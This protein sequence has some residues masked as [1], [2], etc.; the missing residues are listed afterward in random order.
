MSA[1]LRF[2][3]ACLRDSNA[4][5]LLQAN[6]DIFLD[7]QEASAHLYILQHVRAYRQL[8]SPDAV[9]AETGVN[10]PA[11][12]RL[13]DSLRYYED[14]VHA[15][16]AHTSAEE[17]FRNLRE[18]L[19]DKTSEGIA[20]AQIETMNL[21][22]A[23]RGV[24]QQRTI[25]TAGDMLNMMRARFRRALTIDGLPGIPSGWECIDAQTMGYQ[26]GDLITWVAR[27]E[28]GK[29]YFLLWQLLA[30]IMSGRRVLLATTEMTPEQLARRLS[31]I[32]LGLD[33][34][35]LKEARV[36]T[37]TLRRIEAMFTLPE[38]ENNLYCAALG[39]NSGTE[40]LTALH[41][42][43]R[44]DAT[45]VDGAYLLKPR[46]KGNMS[47][48]EKVAEVFDELKQHTIDT[49]SPLVNTAQFNRAAGKGGKEG[50][51][52]SIGMS[53]A[54]SQHSSLVLA[55]KPGST[56][57]PRESRDIEF[58]KGREGETGIYTVRYRFKPVDFSPMSEDE[59]MRADEEAVGV[60][61]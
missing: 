51:L 35:L 36:S 29:T 3:S 7:G 26:D 14:L 20:R 37:Y 57:D 56:A 12:A 34:R 43:L 54:I 47:R 25:A 39:L 6:S 50:S 38:F 5:P 22:H 16:H 61:A 60:N 49:D 13:T 59:I 27:P 17:P 9:R 30:A 10:L 53:D 15:R 44:P 1:G 55:I 41:D 2:I 32:F 31:V 46:K 23:L 42:E 33:P 28:M 4:G 58:I 11:I 48:T 52:E 45:Y 24:R 21:A 40:A 18:A 8:P 19:A